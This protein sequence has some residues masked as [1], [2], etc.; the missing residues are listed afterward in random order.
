MWPLV[1]QVIQAVDETAVA[2]FTALKNQPE[3]SEAVAYKADM[4]A[5][6]TALID[7]LLK[8]CQYA[9]HFGVP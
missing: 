5:Q 7:A 1:L 3:G 9:H 8:S 6:K 4:E 2:C